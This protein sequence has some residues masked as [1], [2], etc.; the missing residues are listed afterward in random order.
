MKKVDLTVLLPCLNEEDSLKDCINKINDY[1][2]RSKVNGEILISDNGSTDSSI[3]IAHKCGARVIHV[4]EKGYGSALRKGIRSSYGKYVIMA[5]ADNSYDLL[6]LE[7]FY[8]NLIT[9]N[10]IVVGN[11]F[12]G[13]IES[14]AM[15]FKNE[16]I[17][18]PI[19]SGTAR[20]LFPTKIHD[21][22]CGLRGFNK[23]A[24]LKL[25]L[26]C[27]GMEF[28]SEMLVKAILNKY[29]IMEVP[30]TLSKSNKGHIPHLKPYRDGLRHL[31]IIFKVFLNKKKYRI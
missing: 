12:K 16:Y 29:K 6:N 9:G 22:H 14:G 26:E 10:D 27:S 20:I 19:L 7:K 3:K 4:K 30:T 25:N 13:G 28:A 5:D 18:N 21:F 2:N 15:P 17:G 31:N 8:D 23:D 11:R 1:F 24:I